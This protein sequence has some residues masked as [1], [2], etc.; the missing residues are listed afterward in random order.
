M[1]KKSKDTNASRAAELQDELEQAQEDV[2]EDVAASPRT[3][4]DHLRFTPDS[5]LADLD[6]HDAPGIDG[7]KLEGQEALAAGAERLSAL[8]ENLYAEGK[9][10]GTRSVL[11]VVQGMDTSGKGGIVRHV[12]GSCDPQ[13]VDHTT[14][15]APTPVEREH[16]FLWRVRPQLPAPGMIGVFDR[17]HYEDV[18]VVRVHDLVPRRVWQRRYA[19]INRFE[20]SV[21]DRGTTVIKVMLHISSGEQRVRLA[22]RLDRPD[23]HWKYHPGDV[24]ERERWADYQTAYD[25]ALRR[26]STEQAPWFVVPADR[27]WYARWAVQQ[28]LIDHLEQLDLQWPVADFDVEQ[29]KARLAAT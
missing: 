3:V 18:L 5:S 21:V 4:G 28:L 20:K 19:A 26:C 17:S 27:K 23:K 14:F 11:L 25:V 24:T 15:K 10:G 7:G 2:L 1:G 9:G 13:G 8:Q 6:P 16:D 12:V 29:E 22:E